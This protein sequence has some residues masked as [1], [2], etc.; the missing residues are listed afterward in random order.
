[1]GTKT[2]ELIILSPAGQGASHGLDFVHG[3]Q[4]S[5]AQS[6]SNCRRRAEGAMAIEADPGA[7]SFKQ[8]AVGCSTNSLAATLRPG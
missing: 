7:K 5:K 6:P 8:W 2:A 4:I 3:A 1:M